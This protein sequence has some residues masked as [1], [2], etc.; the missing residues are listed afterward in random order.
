MITIDFETF[1]IEPR[2]DYPPDPVGVAI[3]RKGGGRG[4]YLAWGH[5][6]GN[7]TTKAKAVR[8]LRQY[9][10]GSEPLLFHN[11]PFDIAVAEERL[12]LRQ[13]PWHRIHDTLSLLFLN[14]PRAPDYHLKESAERI[15]GRRPA[16]RDLLS[17]WIL[18][19][20]PVP[21]LRIT[22]K[23][24]GLPA[25]FV[26][27]V[28]GTIAAAYA[29]GD[30]SRTLHIFNKLYSVIKANDMTEPYDRERRLLPAILKNERR[31][32][33]VNQRL[34]KRDVDLYSHW[35]ER[36][37]HWLEKKLDMPEFKTG[38]ALAKALVD[39]GYATCE[40]LG[41][42]PKGKLKSSRDAVERAVTNRQMIAAL[43]YRGQLQTYLG[44]FMRP[45]LSMAE[46]SGGLIY[47]SWASHR[48]DSGTGAKTGRL[49][50]SPN[51]QN[52]PNPDRIKTYFGKGC[53]RIPMRDLPPLPSVRQYVVPL[54]KDWILFDRDYNQQELRILAHF[55]EGRLLN[56]YQ[57]DPWLD[58]HD[59]V[60]NLVNLALGTNYPRKPIKN[61]NFGLIYPGIKTLYQIVKERAANDEPI[62]TLGGRLYYVEPAKFIE[63]RMR[64]YDWKLVNVLIQGSAADATKE[65]WARY[66]EAGYDD[67]SP[68]LLTVHDE[69][70]G[71]SH[72]DLLYPSQER[73]RQVMESVEC[74]VPLLSDGT[75]SARN[76][77]ELKKFDVKGKI[78]CRV[79]PPE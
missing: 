1:P 25:K 17:E 16:Q 18:K 46:R 63:G 8:E 12:G 2:P 30:V 14:D 62:R 20:Q 57:E 43:S 55:A 77:A 35:L 49:A 78:V 32:V 34:L 73:L 48:R 26:A 45:W 44:T 54:E 75:W 13:P 10:R 76:W 28:P 74:D 64:S 27:Y 19:H 59:H 31:G 23:T 52:V 29:I 68:L 50:S 72:R 33:R 56:D 40:D 11:A 69:L 39:A 9:W 3:Q 37:H 71:S 58:L 7:N 53:P 24:A 65:A 15:L 42:T 38:E 60:R 79:K 36:L 67:E 47:T 61:M 41:Q 21:G 22:P 51:F 4:K 66:H 6:S 70:L 5:P